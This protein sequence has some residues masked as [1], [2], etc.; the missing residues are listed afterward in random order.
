LLENAYNYCFRGL[1]PLDAPYG[2]LKMN[3]SSSRWIEPRRVIGSCSS[4][5]MPA[6]S[7][8]NKTS[9]VNTKF[10]NDRVLYPRIA[11]ETARDS[12]S[13]RD[14]CLQSSRDSSSTDTLPEVP[15]S[16]GNEVRGHRRVQRQSHTKSRTGCFN[17]KRR[18]IKVCRK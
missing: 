16:E 13:S 12:S 2:A 1:W 15:V 9:N 14:L 6:S 4:N 10:M 11:P 8:L 3:K 7:S 18:R 17:C 5:P